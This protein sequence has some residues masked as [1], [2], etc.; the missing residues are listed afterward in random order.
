MKVLI[1]AEIPED[2][3]QA[4]K[5]QNML[6]GFPCDV[7]LTL[8]YGDKVIYPHGKVIGQSVENPFLEKVVVA[9]FEYEHNDGDQIWSDITT[10]YQNTD[11][12]FEK[13]YEEGYYEETSI[14]SV[15]EEEIINKMNEIKHEVEKRKE[16]IAIYGY[17]HPFTRGGYTITKDL[18]EELEIEENKKENP[19]VENNEERDL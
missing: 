2:E 15:S 19:F 8:D 9:S 1:E 13:K 7:Q 10:Y 11:G 18:T 3:L 5:K 12:T 14:V 4:L 6:A 16:T 17:S